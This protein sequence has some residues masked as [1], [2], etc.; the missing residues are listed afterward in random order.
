M[1]VTLVF[2]ILVQSDYVENPVILASTHATEMLKASQEYN[3]EHK[4]LGFCE[5]F[6]SM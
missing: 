1:S 3:L 5:C 6:H 2:Y 4:G